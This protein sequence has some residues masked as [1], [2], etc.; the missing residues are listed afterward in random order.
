MP[1][2][3]RDSERFGALT[4]RVETLKERLDKLEDRGF[5]NRQTATIIGAMLVS[6]TL[7]AVITAVVVLLT[8]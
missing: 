3:D 8:N 1:S 7:S 6:A 4:E 2:F 5:S